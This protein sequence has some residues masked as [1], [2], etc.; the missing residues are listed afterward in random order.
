MIRMPQWLK[1]EAAQFWKTHA[2]GLV[3][4]GMLSEQDADSFALLCD[5][6]RMIR[7]CNPLT[8]S[9]EAIRYN[10]LVKVYLSMSKQ[11]GLMPKDRKKSN[12]EPE[13]TLEDALNLE[14]R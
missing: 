6:W 13:T 11:F 14:K 4:S 5:I 3:E 2:K 12:L 8:D 7:Q 10:G 1:D 9:K